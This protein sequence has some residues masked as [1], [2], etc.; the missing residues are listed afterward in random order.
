MDNQ[1]VVPSNPGPFSSMQP[2]P[3]S[4]API[5]PILLG[6]FILGTI[7]FAVLAYTFQSLAS[8]S[9]NALAA[10]KT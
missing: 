7:V 2:A 10:A 3:K 4:G 6:L 9:K 1:P 8:K 5:I